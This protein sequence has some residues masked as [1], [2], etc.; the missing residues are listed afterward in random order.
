MSE[1]KAPKGASAAP[2]MTFG[3]FVLSVAHSA[4]EQLRQVKAPAQAD[5]QAALALAKQSID[6]L[7]VMEQ[8]TKGNLDEEET[9]LLSALLYELRMAYMAAQS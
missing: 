5:A 6:L 3:T 4:M 2:P 8:K 7:E 9:R 1:E